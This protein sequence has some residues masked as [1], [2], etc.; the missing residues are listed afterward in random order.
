M[1]VVTNI[2]LAAIF[3]LFGMFEY[4]TIAAELV[5]D[6][7]VPQI[8]I[9]LTYS[10]GKLADAEVMG[11]TDTVESCQRSIAAF[12]ATIATKPDVEMTGVCTP[13]PPPPAVRKQE[14]AE[15]L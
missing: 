12:L 14:P 3:P 10:G 7:D 9:V 6:E 11:T 13:L 2:L 5:A 1:K 15:R 8:A 4:R